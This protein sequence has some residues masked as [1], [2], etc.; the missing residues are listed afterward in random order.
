MNAQL[1]LIQSNPK[2]SIQDLQALLDKAQEAYDRASSNLST[3]CT[4]NFSLAHT[5]INAKNE[6]VLFDFEAGA[7]AARIAEAAFI[8]IKQGMKK[9]TDSQLAITQSSLALT[10]LMAAKSLAEASN[11]AQEIVELQIRMTTLQKDI[12]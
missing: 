12:T 8:N 6:F 10:L 3:T 5:S 9:S 2:Q 7:K 1:A 11:T 4:S